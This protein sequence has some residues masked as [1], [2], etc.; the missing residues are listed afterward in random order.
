MI[1]MVNFKK[2]DKGSETFIQ[3]IK[4]ICK[5]IKKYFNHFQN[6]ILKYHHTYWK[7]I[8]HNEYEYDYDLLLL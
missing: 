5:R 1:M 6:K 7:I 3:K 4:F 2:N 8:F